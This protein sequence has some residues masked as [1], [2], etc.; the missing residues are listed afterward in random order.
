M[1]ERLTAAAGEVVD[2]ARAHARRLGNPTTEPLH[3]LLALCEDAD[4]PAVSVLNALGASPEVVRARAERAA[5]GSRSRFARR[6]P[7]GR[8]GARVLEL[9]AWEAA[10]LGRRETDV[11]H[12]LLG[13]LHFGQGRACAALT[14]SGVHLA[15]ARDVVAASARSATGSP[16][17]RPDASP[18][19]VP[20]P[21]PAA[22]GREVATA[23]HGSVRP[24]EP[25]APDVPDAPAVVDVPAASD[26]SDASDGPGAVDRPGVADLF[27]GMDL[28]D[29]V[30][31]PDGADLAEGADR[32]EGTGL[33]DA[34]DPS[35]V[36]P[37]S[38]VSEARAE[39]A[40]V[41]E[42]S[43]GGDAPV[44]AARPSVAAPSAGDG[45]SGGRRESRYG[46]GRYDEDLRQA[47]VLADG[48]ARELGHQAVHPA[49]LLLGLAGVGGAT[50]RH[51]VGLGVRADEVLDRA[52]RAMGA[53]SGSAPRREGE[54][55]FAPAA[56][57]VLRATAE[58]GEAMGHAHLGTEHLLCALLGEADDLPARVLGRYGLTA[59]A[60][61]HAALVAG[62][63]V[64]RSDVGTQV[65]MS[66]SGSVP[67]ISA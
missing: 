19:A 48:E 39:G 38:E 4:G 51:L 22:P 56:Q 2:R 17:T 15:A 67:V 35:E 34:V 8:A 33:P 28:P 50:D 58:L 27:D 45:P 64:P 42:A 16:V 6:V 65:Q 3:L 11:E 26:V 24:A 7:V 66:A 20:P 61:R 12:V 40:E 54:A 31:L 36:A 25:D 55:K 43:E 60:A 49:H 10:E 1:A 47:L 57:C 18:P 53:A 5:D 30:D 46:F 23:H 32:P 44:G 9:A 14:A 59:E 13:V 37:V 62:A 21:A 29:G 41:V 63:R 52:H